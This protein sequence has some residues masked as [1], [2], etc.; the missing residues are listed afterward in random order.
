MDVG[1]RHPGRGVRRR[2]LAGC[3][4]VRPGDVVRHPVGVVHLPD[5]V[6]HLGVGHRPDVVPDGLLWR[7]GCL[8]R[9]VHVHLAWGLALPLDV[10]LRLDEEP[11]HPASGW[12]S[13]R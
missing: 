9:A 2:D 13:P 1:H 5:V 12:T 10:A 11:R 3:H 8:P 7:M 4:A 6:R